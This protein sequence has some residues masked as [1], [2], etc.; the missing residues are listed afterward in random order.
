MQNVPRQLKIAAKIV[1]ARLPSPYQ[2]WRKI[3]IFKQGGMDRPEYALA[4]FRR[5]F[6]AARLA[7][8]AE[9][10]G[11]RSGPRRFAVLGIDCI[12]L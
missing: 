1:L 9:L 12:R 2:F 5:H 10:C 8:K 3:A 7:G 6:E 11:A 4:I